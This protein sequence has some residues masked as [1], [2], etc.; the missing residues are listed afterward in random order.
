M[1]ESQKQA[2]GRAGL[3]LIDALYEDEIQESIGS[4]M[5]EIFKDHP[6]R[7]NTE[8]LLRCAFALGV[9]A[10]TQK[11]FNPTELNQ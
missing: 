8:R 4:I 10:A 9:I 1:N 7:E 2:I 6:Q 5:A 3:A 11:P